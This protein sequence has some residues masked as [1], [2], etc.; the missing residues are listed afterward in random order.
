MSYTKAQT[1]LML[2]IQMLEA[3]EQPTTQQLVYLLNA[4]LKIVDK[5]ITKVYS[6]LTGSKSD[7]DLQPL[8]TKIL[9]K[10]KF[11]DF[12]TFVG[13]ITNDNKKEKLFW[14]IYEG[15]QCLAKLNRSAALATKVAK[16]GGTIIAK[17]ETQANLI[18]AA[19]TAAT[20]AKRAAKKAA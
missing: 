6:M 19:N 5:S 1:E 13:L 3:I 18:N 4:K 17:T 8:I 15:I 10:A 11:P 9:G 2:R 7:K 20:K 12:K 14:S 16:Q